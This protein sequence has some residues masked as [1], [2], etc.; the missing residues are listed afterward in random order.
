MMK[1]KKNTLLLWPIIF[2]LGFIPMIVHMYTYDCMLQQFEWF[3]DW[4]SSQTDFFSVL[5]DDCNYNHR[6]CHAMCPAF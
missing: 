1:E 4:S 3:P 6:C 2:A 5:Q